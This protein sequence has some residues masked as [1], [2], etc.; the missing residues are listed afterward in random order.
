MFVL[1]TCWGKN[2]LLLTAYSFQNDPPGQSFLLHDPKGSQ[3]D[4]HHF[5]P[6]LSL[7]LCHDA[8]HRV[9]ENYKIYHLK[10]LIV[11]LYLF[12]V[13]SVQQVVTCAETKKISQY[14]GNPR[15]DVGVNCQENIVELDNISRIYN[16]AP[17]SPNLLFSLLKWPFQSIETSCSL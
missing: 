7:H 3:I 8:F 2:Q 5:A 9:S 17:I 16:P 4:Y 12:F 11:I 15:A 14:E 10:V 1:K 6:L 13:G